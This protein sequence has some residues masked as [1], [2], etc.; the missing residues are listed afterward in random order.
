MNRRLALWCVATSPV[1]PLA[2]LL[3][4]SAATAAGRLAAVCAL[5]LVAAPALALAGRARMARALGVVLLACGAALVAMAPSGDA[6][7]GARVRAVYLRGN[8]PWRIAPTNLV[9]E[10]DQLALATHLVWLADPVLTRSGAARLRALVRRAYAPVE[11]DP[12]LR[13]LGS[14]LG[15]AIANRDSGRVYVY[16]P[17]HAPGERRPAML[18][19]HGSAGSWKGYLHVLLGLARRRRMGLAQPSFGFGN[20]NAP[21]GV[22]A[23]ERTRRWLTAQPWVDPSRVY[24]ACLSNGGRGVTRTMQRDASR[25]RATAFLSAVIE[26]RVLDAGALHPSWRDAP[27]LVLHGARDDRIPLDYLDEGVAALRDQGV[28]VTVRLHPASDHF[29]VFDDARFVVEETSAWLDRVE[30]ARP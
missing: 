21:G 2:L 5:L 3:L 14:A 8:G 20:W 16:E 25:Y 11:R 7:P 12:E 29:L 23:I 27:A 24:L 22:D 19:L 30:A 1:A 6:P 10:A 18:F 13:A 4:G 15:D 28:D 17:E 9:P 26:P